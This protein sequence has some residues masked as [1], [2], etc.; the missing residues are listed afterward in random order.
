[1]NVYC[2]FKAEKQLSSSLL[3]T[4]PYEKADNTLASLRAA[5]HEFVV[6]EARLQDCS[7][8]DRLQEMIGQANSIKE[9]LIAKSIFY[10]TRCPIA[11]EKNYDCSEYALKKILKLPINLK[12]TVEKSRFCV[13]HISKYFEQ[14]PTPKKNDLVCYSQKPYYEDIKHLGIFTDFNRV[15]SKWGGLDII[16]H[17]LFG[18]PIA[19]GNYAMY[20][21]LKDEYKN[22]HPDQF[23]H[24]IMHDKAIVAFEFKKNLCHN[25]LSLYSM[26]AKKDISLAKRIIDT[27][28]RTS[29]MVMD[30][31]DFDFY[32]EDSSR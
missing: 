26:M 21:T 15:E 5:L 2:M 11:E 13:F 30:K 31:V 24:I 29:D 9:M 10:S 8:T 1:M 4:H 27:H 3:I 14:T 18:I 28:I 12:T 16:E 25:I 17:H 6:E 20:L 19:Y 7:P 22:L 32:F 23:I